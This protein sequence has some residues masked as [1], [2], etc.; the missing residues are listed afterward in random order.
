MQ[1]I[2]AGFGI[3]DNTPVTAKNEPTEVAS[4]TTVSPKRG[5]NI[6]TIIN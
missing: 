5:A 2:Y 4:L 3:V 6:D 1:K